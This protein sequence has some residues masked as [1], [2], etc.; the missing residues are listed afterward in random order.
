MTEPRATTPMLSVVLVTDEF[1][2]ISEVIEAFASQTVKSAIEIVMVLPADK[3]HEID[4]SRLA[5]FAASRVVTVPS[6][7]PMPPARAAGVRAATAPVVFIG[8]THSY[9]QPEFAAAI[10]DAHKGPWDVVVPGLDNANP[11]LARSWASFLLDYGYWMAGLPAAQVVSGPT[12]NAS[13]KAHTL[14]EMGSSLD[15]ALSSGDELPMALR[16]RNRKFYF[17]PRARITHVNLESRGWIDERYLSGLVVGAN[18]KKR[19]SL[20][21]RIAYF[22]GSPLIP[23]VLIYRNAATMRHLYGEKRLPAGTAVAVAAGAVIR[24]AGEAVGYLFGIRHAAESRMED[25]ELKKLS[26]VSM[27]R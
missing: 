14:L 2:T 6:I 9:P 11:A 23:F 25:Y 19:F 27:P 21:R 22:F 17:E 24:S 5:G 1:A 10:I 26:Y 3:A 7:L 12:W 13:Y 16:A 8:E 15:G 4:R 18:R 20:S